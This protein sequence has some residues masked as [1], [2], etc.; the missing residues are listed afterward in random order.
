M[1]VDKIK[2]AEIVLICFFEFLFRY[3][4]IVEFVVLNVFNKKNIEERWFLFISFLAPFYDFAPIFHKN[5][6]RGITKAQPIGDWRETFT[7]ILK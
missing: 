2:P 1:P 7:K 3:L 6:A 4:L 5:S